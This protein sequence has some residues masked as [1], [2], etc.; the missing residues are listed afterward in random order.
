MIINKQTAGGSFAGRIIM[1]AIPR[2]EIYGLET[3]WKVTSRL[4]IPGEKPAD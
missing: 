1:L 3:S 4:G 2:K